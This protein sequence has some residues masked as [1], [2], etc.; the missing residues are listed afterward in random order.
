MKRN[1]DN[2][3]KELD[4]SEAN[5]FLDASSIHPKSENYKTKQAQDFV[6]KMNE[7]QAHHRRSVERIKEKH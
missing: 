4:T 7:D 2:F 1:I 6:K 5:D 3:K